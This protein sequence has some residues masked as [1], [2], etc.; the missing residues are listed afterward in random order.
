MGVLLVPLRVQ[1]Y[2]IWE[3]IYIASVVGIVMVIWGIYFTYLG[4]C[5]L[6]V[7]F[8]LFGVFVGVTDFWKLA[9]KPL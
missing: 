4:I 2:P 8:L 7:S 1:Q 5:T 6:R 9:Y 3:G